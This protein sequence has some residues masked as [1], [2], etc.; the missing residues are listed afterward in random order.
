MG[1]TSFRNINPTNFSCS[2]SGLLG[3]IMEFLTS[4]SR[5]GQTN[6]EGI[7]YTLDNQLFKDFDGNIYLT[8]R[9]TLTDG[10]T[11]PSIFHF[12][13][14][15]KFM[16]DV[17]ACIQHDFECY[18]RKV[19]KVKLSI[20][21]LRKSR[22][23]RYENDMWIC[24]DIPLQFLSIED[25]TFQQT[26]ERFRRMLDCLPNIKGWQRKLIGSAV[27]FNVGWLKEPHTL[28]TDRLYRIDYEQVR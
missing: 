8:P 1:S 14:G 3:V 28:H 19:L 16:H 2:P 5:L 27:N 13:V 21:E 18:H 25:T 17:R 4:K 26:N 20:F 15:G 11:I 7:W 9:N 6:I 22:L 23:L 10:Y 12:L 24:E